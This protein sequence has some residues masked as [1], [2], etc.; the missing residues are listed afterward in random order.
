VRL[1]TMLLSLAVAYLVTAGLSAEA[2]KVIA[3]KQ[4]LSKRFQKMDANHDGIL[5]EAEFVTAHSKLDAAQAKNCYEALA[6]LSGTTTK[7]GATGMTF[8]QFKKAALA[9][10]Q[11]HKKPT[12]TQ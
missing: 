4:P 12:A 10:R 2:A 6:A 8:P 9:W 7:N 5:T 3:K 11:S 1:W